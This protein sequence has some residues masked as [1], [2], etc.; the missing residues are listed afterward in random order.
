METMVIIM[1]MM[2]TTTMYVKMN[3]S[4]RFKK[5]DEYI[6]LDPGDYNDKH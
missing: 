4:L 1:M 3:L 2:M 6:D 5:N